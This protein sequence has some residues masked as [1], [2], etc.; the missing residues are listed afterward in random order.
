MSLS[1]LSL[2]SNVGAVSMPGSSLSSAVSGSKLSSK[3]GAEFGSSLSS[4]S[5]LSLLLSSSL[6]EFGDHKGDCG[7]GEGDVPQPIKGCMVVLIILHVYNFF[8]L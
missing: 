3:V 8:T 5:G 1:G 4:A 6:L 2:S 7:G